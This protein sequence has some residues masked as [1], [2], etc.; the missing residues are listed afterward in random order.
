[1]HLY[2]C[3]YIYIY[4][5]TIIKKQHIKFLPDTECCQKR[6]LYNYNCS[7]QDLKAGSTNL[8]LL[9][10]IDFESLVGFGVMGKCTGGRE[11]D[12]AGTTNKLLIV[13][14]KNWTN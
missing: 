13:G 2:A 11:P 8:I 9:P 3:V 6:N 5:R 1:M 4:T 12:K 10:L 14:G 7:L